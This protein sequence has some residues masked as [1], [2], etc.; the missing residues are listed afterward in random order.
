MGAMR[1][2]CRT[3]RRSVERQNLPAGM[4]AIRRLRELRINRKKVDAPETFTALEQG[5]KER[6]EALYGA[7]KTNDQSGSETALTAMLEQCNAC[8][9][10][11]RALGADDVLIR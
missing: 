1:L 7:M 2:D 5:L 3:V 9:T 6:V 4:K 10:T 8:H 11:Y